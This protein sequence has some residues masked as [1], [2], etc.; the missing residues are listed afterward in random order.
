MKDETLEETAQTLIL[1]AMGAM[2][3]H[4]LKPISMEELMTEE[5]QDNVASVF[6]LTRVPKAPDILNNDMD[7]LSVQMAEPSRNVN[8]NEVFFTSDQYGFCL[9]APKCRDII[10]NTPVRL[11]PGL[12]ATTSMSETC[13]SKRTDGRD[14]RDLRAAERLFST[15]RRDVEDLGWIQATGSC[16]ISHRPCGT[17]AQGLLQEVFANTNQSAERVRRNHGPGR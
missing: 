5:A 13:R 17:T 12:E 4:P 15:T 8:V 6:F 1:K 14:P 3:A 2:S 7:V 9:E 10:T 11:V 16:L